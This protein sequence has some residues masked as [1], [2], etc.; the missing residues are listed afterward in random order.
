MGKKGQNLFTLQSHIAQGEIN[1]P[2][3]ERGWNT[4]CPPY[5][6]NLKVKL[7]LVSKPYLPF[8][9]T[10]SVVCY[11]SVPLIT[12][13]C[14]CFPKPVDMRKYL[15][16]ILSVKFKH[17]GFPEF[18]IIAHAIRGVKFDLKKPIQLEVQN[19]FILYML[20]QCKGLLPFCFPNKKA[21]GKH[22]NSENT[23]VK[24]PAS[25]LHALTAQFLPALQPRNSV[26][27]LLL[28]N[29]KNIMQFNTSVSVAKIF[30]A[31]QEARNWHFFHN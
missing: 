16:T 27:C 13:Y 28:G 10:L 25:P 15:N 26:S 2:S 9:A 4:K 17:C 21:K 7:P 6:L 23:E 3:V 30:T 11:T 14:H 19:V 31:V 29:V 24:I 1:D 8:Q 18:S 5:K 22:C 20:Q 12:N